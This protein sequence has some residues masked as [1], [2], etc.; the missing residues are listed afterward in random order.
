MPE[1]AKKTLVLSIYFALA[2]STLLVFW[3]VRNFDFINYDDNDYIYENCNEWDDRDVDSTFD[4]QWANIHW[5]DRRCAERQ[6]D[7]LV[8]NERD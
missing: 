3:Q 2:V 6:P 7:Y 5:M 8:L 4:G 1:Q